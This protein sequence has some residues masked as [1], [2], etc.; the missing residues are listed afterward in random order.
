M[1][2]LAATALCAGD[3]SLVWNRSRVFAG[4][5]AG[6]CIR[7]GVRSFLLPCALAIHVRAQESAADPKRWAFE[8][9]EMGVPFRITVYASDAESARKGA[10]AAF[11]RVAALNAVL[12]DYDSDSELS[13]LSAS[14]GEGR[15]VPVSPDLWKVLECAQRVAERSGGAF[16]LSVGPLVNLWR[17]A[18][19]KQELPPAARISEALGRVGYRSIVLDP[20]TR[21]ARLELARMRLDAGGIAKGFA[22]QEAV[23]VLRAHGLERCMVEG[24]G[25]VALGAAP[26]G[27]AGWRIEAAQLDHPGA[28][29]AHIL[30]VARCC[31]AT[32]GDRYQRV[33][34]G[35]VR[36]SH[37]V[38]PWTGVGLTDHSVVMVVSPSG[39]EADA[40]SKVVSV[41]G[42]ELGIP[43]V[44]EFSGARVRVVR[45][46]EG[47]V[48]E[49]QSAG[50]KEIV[51]AP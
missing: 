23:E 38:D 14:S 18:R 48:E 41:L 13:R 26:P 1:R 10:E 43:L 46:P 50:W 42:P 25:D 30:E 34:V 2:G 35:G 24:G 28:P 45:A 3:F 32:S 8:K 36:Y 12:T 44:E 40:L 16:D 9:A 19:R 33:Q 27:R 15:W 47:A 4:L 22:V 21:S 29:A 6:W 49:R 7:T 31:V 11:E 17:A 39:I 20:G 51:A 37:I 5:F